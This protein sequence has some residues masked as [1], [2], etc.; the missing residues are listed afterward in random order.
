MI[1]NIFIS[2][3]LDLTHL[4]SPYL[5]NDFLLNQMIVDIYVVV[6]LIEHMTK[7]M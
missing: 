5:D 7:I 2:W 3:W 1:V 6:S 4:I